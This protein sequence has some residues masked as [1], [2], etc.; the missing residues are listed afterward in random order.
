MLTLLPGIEILMIHVKLDQTEKYCLNGLEIH[1][2][3]LTECELF[4]LEYYDKFK[5][6]FCLFYIVI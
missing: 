4:T 6:L 5:T 3:M 1:V 2:L